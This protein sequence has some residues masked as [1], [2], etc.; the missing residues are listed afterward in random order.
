MNKQSRNRVQKHRA[1]Q[2]AK[3]EE[4]EQIEKII[5]ESCLQDNT[6]SLIKNKNGKFL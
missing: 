5:A 3:K 2:K 6:S 1:V 4:I